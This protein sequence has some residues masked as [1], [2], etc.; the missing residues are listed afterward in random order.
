MGMWYSGVTKFYRSIYAIADHARAQGLVLY[1]AGFWGEMACR[2]FALFQV[3]P[4]AFCDDDPQKQGTQLEYGGHMIPVLSLD[5]A[6]A[7]MPNAVYIATVTSGGGKDAPRARMNRRLKERGLLSPDSGFHPLR[8]LFLLEGGMEAI[9]HPAELDEDSFRPEHLNNMVV[10]NHMSNSGSVFLGSLVDGHPN[11]LSIAILNCCIP[12]VEVYSQRL[13][14]LEGKE[15]VLE[16]ASQMTPYFATDFPDSVYGQVMMRLSDSFYRGADG[17]PENRL[18]ISPKE[19][20]RALEAVLADQGHVSFAQLLKALFAAYHNVIGKKYVP[21]QDYWIFFMRHQSNYDIQ[22]MKDLVRHGEFKRLEYWFIIREPVQHAFSWMRRFILEGEEYLAFSFGNPS[23]YLDRFSS[24][25][26]LMLRK[27]GNNDSD[28]VKVVRFEDVKAS[29]RQTMQAVCESLGVPFDE[30][31]LEATVNGI[32]VYFPASSDGHSKDVISTQDT[33]ALK[34]RDFSA[35]MT[36]FDVF[37]LNLVFQ[38]F[39]RAYGYD[40]DVP[41]YRL[42]S[43][44]FL[45]ELYRHPFRFESALNHCGREALEKGYLAPDERPE[46]HDYLVKLFL[47]YMK[48]ERRE[49]FT[50]II[51]S[52]TDTQVKG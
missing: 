40:C 42:F 32:V 10:F 11:I 5:E 14:F 17:K 27:S 44:A 33:T 46:C 20:I 34:R 19:F 52:K 50:D 6:A 35:L 18:Y 21:G 51:R 30:C 37:R 39:K 25:L 22:E 31:V 9:G 24:D 23:E 12:L 16:T 1:G 49:L 43:E 41:D 48:E 26:G 36:S 4:T 47:D 38:D 3:F 8:Y 13:Q 29:T 15:L 45:E 2:I 7:R 28:A